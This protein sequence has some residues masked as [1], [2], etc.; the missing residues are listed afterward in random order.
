MG[1]FDAEVIVVGGGPAGSATAS[2]L[3]RAGVDVMLLDRAHFPREKACAEYL[4]PQ[5]SRLLAELGALELIEQAGPAHL[6][7]M[8]IHAPNGRSFLGEFDAPHGFRGFSD[9]GLAL[10]RA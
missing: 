8:R 6:K 3:A 10:R 5:A 9:Y 4:S 7:G 1:A 2:F